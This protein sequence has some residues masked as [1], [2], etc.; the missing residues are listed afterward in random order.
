[1]E[2]P[3]SGSFIHAGLQLTATAKTSCAKVKAEM[4]ARISGA[5]GWK[6]PHN[7]GIYSVLSETSNQLKTQ[8][9]TNPATSVGG[10]V[11]TDKQIF[12]FIDGAD[13]LVKSRRAA[14]AKVS[15]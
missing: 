14:R 13:G 12:T 10:Q 8:R 11:Y 2:C 4:Q 15:Q 9:T 3:S 7:G 5:N 6:D 1:M